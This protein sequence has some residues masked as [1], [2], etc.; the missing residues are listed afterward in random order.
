LVS[1][2][3]CK[4]VNVRLEAD[5][6]KD[7]SLKAAIT[8]AQAADGDSASLRLE[9]VAALLQLRSQADQDIEWKRE[10]CHRQ[11]VIAEAAAAVAVCIWTL[12]SLHSKAWRNAALQV[13][14]TAALQMCSWYRMLQDAQRAL[15]KSKAELQGDGQTV[16]G[17]ALSPEPGHNH[18]TDVKAQD[19][20]PLHAA[21]VA[22]EQG[23]TEANAA[24]AT[25][26]THAQAAWSS[27]QLYWVKDLASSPEGY[28]EAA[29]AGVPIWSVIHL[30]TVEADSSTSTSEPAKGQQP[31]APPP[32]KLFQHLKARSASSASDDAINK[33]ALIDVIAGQEGARFVTPGMYSATDS[34]QPCSPPILGAG[35]MQQAL[36][37]LKAC[38]QRYSKWQHSHTAYMLDACKAEE[39]GH[40]NNLMDPV[41]PEQQ[42]VAVVLHSMIEQVDQWH[43]S[44]I[45]SSGHAADLQQ[46]IQGFDAAFAA[47]E[48]V[49]AHIVGGTTCTPVCTA[50]MDGDAPGLAAC[51]ALSGQI[52]PAS[53]CHKNQVCSPFFVDAAKVEERMA[54]LCREVD[55]HPA[56]D[57][58]WGARH[59]SALHACA[60]K[61]CSP[62]VEALCVAC[63]CLCCNSRSSGSI[64]MLQLPVSHCGHAGGP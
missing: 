37:F 8:E 57:G 19:A 4:C 56:D 27:T 33:I 20:S 52:R 49:S 50:V 17:A 6:I 1:E 15:D 31:P 28:C 47:Y 23:L 32:Q 44:A 51:G 40:Y 59:N 16:S 7:V 61:V 11:G 46:A 63:A 36:S 48:D 54:A 12:R 14:I 18:S 22:A 55:L 21:I 25:A 58:H 24:L 5:R 29:N 45:E 42:S 53:S 3:V 38:F 60:S 2:R 30:H 26:Q 34:D 9:H 13:S 62:N 43:L 10:Y 64:R 39:F 41:P 35:E